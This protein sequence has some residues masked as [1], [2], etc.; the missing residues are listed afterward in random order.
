LLSTDPD[1]AE[2]HMS[3]I[4]FFYPGDDRPAG[5]IE[6]GLDPDVREAIERDAGAIGE[7]LR[8][9]NQIADCRYA[10]AEW[11][12]ALPLG[13]AASVGGVGID[14]PDYDPWRRLIPLDR[15]SGYREGDGEVHRHFWI[16]IG[17]EQRIFDP[18]AHQFDGRGGLSIGGYT[19]AGQPFVEA[20]R[21]K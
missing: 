5:V 21:R 1:A 11:L 20:R 9:M 18:T 16:A 4:D 8:V 17:L 7:S 6:H 3:L 14:E 10:A 12:R 15:R 2:G 19:I 13:L